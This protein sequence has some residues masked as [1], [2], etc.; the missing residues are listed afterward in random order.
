MQLTDC[1]VRYL[2]LDVSIYSVV[3]IWYTIIVDYNVDIMNNRLLIF[4]KKGDEISNK[5]VG[6]LLHDTMGMGGL[7]SVIDAYG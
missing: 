2:P 5:Y 7:C 6:M 1:L 4:L 3:K